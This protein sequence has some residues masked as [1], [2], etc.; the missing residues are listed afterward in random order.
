MSYFSNLLNH[1]NRP[2]LLNT[3]L[4]GNSL[5][6]LQCIDIKESDKGYPYAFIRYYDLK[7]ACA[8]KKYLNEEILHERSMKVIDDFFC[9]F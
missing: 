6:N 4:I 8:A 7:S 1:L 9:P 3:Y 5:M 2:K